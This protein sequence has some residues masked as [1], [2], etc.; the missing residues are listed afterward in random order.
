M[1]RAGLLVETPRPEQRNLPRSGE[2]KAALYPDAASIL[3]KKKIKKCQSRVR[4][5]QHILNFTFKSQY[6]II[7]P[8][9]R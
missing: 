1:S 2:A 6:Y 7:M 8:V 4:E 3:M 9:A 5:L